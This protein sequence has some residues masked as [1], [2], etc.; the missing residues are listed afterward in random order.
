MICYGVSYLSTGFY[1]GKT[2]H[3]QFIFFLMAPN[4]DIIGMHKNAIIISKKKV[5]KQTDKQTK[6]FVTLVFF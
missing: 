2:Q 5:K 4:P 3:L 1:Y 6:N